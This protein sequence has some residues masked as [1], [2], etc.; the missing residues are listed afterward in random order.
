[1]YEECRRYH[2]P[3][4]IASAD[5]NPKEKMAMIF[6]WYFGYSGRLALAGDPD[7][8]V[9]Y[10]IY[11]GPALGAFNQMVKGTALEAWQNRHVDEIAQFLMEQTAELL[12]KRIRS[13]LALGKSELVALD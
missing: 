3:A 8:Q 13:M 9:D 12:D 7:N 4:R 2:P 10:Q 1:V 5:K 6:K 11:C